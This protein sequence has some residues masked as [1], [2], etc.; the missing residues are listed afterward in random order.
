MIQVDG[1]IYTRFYNSFDV[2][3]KKH[4]YRCEDNAFSHVRIEL[5]NK[6]DE[7]VHDRIIMPVALG[8]K[9]EIDYK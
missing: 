5:I 3:T 2:W 8:L 9:N 4:E 1:K 7:S 6:A